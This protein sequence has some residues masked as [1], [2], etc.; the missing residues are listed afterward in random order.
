MEDK[1]GFSLRQKKSSRRPAI[2]APRQISNQSTTAPPIPEG[3]PHANGHSGKST[4]GS[5][6]RIGRPGGNTADLVKRRYST[7]FVQLSDFNNADAPPMPNGH[8]QHQ[9]PIFN[10]PAPGQTRNLNVDIPALKDP[11][12]DAEK[13][14]SSKTEKPS[15]Y[16]STAKCYPKSNPIHQ[17]Q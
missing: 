17:N 6:E 11:N 10:L 13:Y 8:L 14:K 16:R 3:H 4:K 1:K 12:L 15:I 9:N 2:S 5:K 7:R